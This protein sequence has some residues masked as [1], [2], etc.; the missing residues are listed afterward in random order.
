M[1][2]FKEYNFTLTSLRKDVL[3]I[4]ES[5]KSPL[6]AYDILDILSKKRPNAKPPT[7]YRVLDF[8]VRQ[9]VVHKVNSN[10]TYVICQSNTV[11]SDCEKHG[12]SMDLILVCENCHQCLEITNSVASLVLNQLIKEKEFAIS[13]RCIELKGICNTCKTIKRL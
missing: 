12:K 10:H 7:V 13:E 3:K 8:L 9:H 1:E 4:I 11:N 5:A 2:N 6:K